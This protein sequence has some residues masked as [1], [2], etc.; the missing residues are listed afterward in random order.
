MYFKNVK[1]DDEVF[2]LVFGLGKVTKVYTD[3]HYELEVEYENGSTVPY[4]IEGNPAWNFGNDIQTVFYKNDINIMDY[5]ISP[6]D[7][8]LNIKQIIKLRTVG[9]LLV[10]CESGIW[11][12]VRECPGTEVE[13]LL[14]NEQFHRFKKA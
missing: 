9:K 2:G 5:D 4:T 6:T 14:E 12:D 3:S 13:L 7:K 8:I 1:L 11:R 10:R